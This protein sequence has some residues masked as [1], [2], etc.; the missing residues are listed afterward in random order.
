MIG[1]VVFSKAG[2]DKGSLMVVVAEEK[3]VCFVCD[4]KKRKLDSPKRKNPRHL[5][6]T[7]KKISEDKII[8]NRLIRC[9]LLKCG[10]TVK[11]GKQCQNQI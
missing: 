2:K 1:T 11:G 8:T 5:C 6:F 10:E 4:G 9:E 3:K 7:D